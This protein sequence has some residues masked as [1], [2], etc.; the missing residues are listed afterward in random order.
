M[1][2]RCSLTF[3]SRAIYYYS[4]IFLSTDSMPLLVQYLARPCVTIA[5]IFIVILHIA[6]S[7]T[8]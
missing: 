2:S 1:N 8:W 5:A 6:I 7:F 3:R 4:N